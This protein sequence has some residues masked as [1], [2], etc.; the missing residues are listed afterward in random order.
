LK[1]IDVSALQ[2]GLYMLEVK[3]KSKIVRYKVVK[4]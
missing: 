1:K 4:I 2:S 3:S